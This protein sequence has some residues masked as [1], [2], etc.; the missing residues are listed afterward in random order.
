VVNRIKTRIEI[1]SETESGRSKYQSWEAGKGAKYV[2]IEYRTGILAE[3]VPGS[4][5]ERD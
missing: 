2:M 3:E 1:G 5:V 4:F